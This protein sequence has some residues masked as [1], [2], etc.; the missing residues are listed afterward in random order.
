MEHR[1]G[2]ALAPGG[3]HTAVRC[4]LEPSWTEGGREREREREGGN[5]IKCDEH[6]YFVE[7]FCQ[8]CSL[9]S[10]IITQIFLL[11]VTV[12][13]YIENMATFTIILFYW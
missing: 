10:K 2:E 12:N 6:K 3:G 1:E 4:S 9:L 8:F 13:D 7:I 5:K 11:T